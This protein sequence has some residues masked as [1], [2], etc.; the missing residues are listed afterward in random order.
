M[1]NVILVTLLFLIKFDL[2]MYILILMQ[3]FSYYSSIEIITLF[4]VIVRL[5]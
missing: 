5:S 3:L 2:E 4:Y 1:L